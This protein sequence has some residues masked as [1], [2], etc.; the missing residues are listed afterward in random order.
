MTPPPR[1]IPQAGPAAWT[2]ST[3]PPP[4]WMVPVGAEPAAEL[5]TA[6]A[7]PAPAK[8][9]L[10]AGVLR[11]VAERLEHGR[12]FCLL[13]GLN[14]DRLADPD[15]ALLMLGAQLG[16]ALPQDAAGALVGRLAGPGAGADTPA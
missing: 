11:N 10:L 9:P 14:L 13:R 8:L 7:G 12:G 5:E 16:T 2:G 6:I 3:P 15:A 4:D 1:L